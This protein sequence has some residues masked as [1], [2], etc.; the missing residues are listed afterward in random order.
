MNTAGEKNTEMTAQIERH[1]RKCSKEG[2]RN[3]KYIIKIKEEKYHVWRVREE[4]CDLIA[5]ILMTEISE[6]E[7]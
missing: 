4:C 3:N 7:N 5:T 2:Q 1:S 6:R